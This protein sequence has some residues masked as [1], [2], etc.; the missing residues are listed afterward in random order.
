MKSLLSSGKVGGDGV[1]KNWLKRKP[2]FPLFP[3]KRQEPC[4]FCSSQYTQSP[5][6]G[7]G[8]IQFSWMNEWIIISSISVTLY[9]LVKSLYTGSHRTLKEFS[10]II[11][12]TLLFLFTGEEAKRELRWLACI[13]KPTMVEPGLGPANSWSGAL[14]P[15]LQCLLNM[16]KS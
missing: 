7:W 11:G 16:N 15:T 2:M 14:S 13:T 10:R 3:T 12:Q 4:F 9:I 5:A 1:R 6:C 8:P